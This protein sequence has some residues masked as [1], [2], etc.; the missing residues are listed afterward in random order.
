MTRR[1]RFIRL[2]VIAVFGLLAACSSIDMDDIDFGIFRPDKSEKA[3]TQKTETPVAK[4]KPAQLAKSGLMISEGDALFIKTAPDSAWAGNF[5]VSPKGS[6]SR[7]DG[8]T[9]KIAGLDV[10]VAE[11]RV[12]EAI[13]K[14]SDASVTVRIQILNPSPVYILGEINSPGEFPYVVGLTVSQL[15]H[16][17]GGY[18]HRADVEQATVSRQG[19]EAKIW[20][21]MDNPIDILPGDIIQIPQKYF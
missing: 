18:T 3:E 5:K 16:L 9:L 17:A 13:E 12:G 11:K 10:G 8:Q 2:F 15:V 4:E 20:V 7:F 21:S 1:N 6:I 14:D 19:V